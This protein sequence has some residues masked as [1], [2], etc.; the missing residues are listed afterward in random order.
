MQQL[1]E[2]EN[3]IWDRKLPETVIERIHLTVG[4]TPSDANTIVDVGSGDGRIT[5]LLRRAGYDPVACDISHGALKRIQNTRRVQAS[6]D[7]LPF[8]SFSF[9]LVIAS[10]LI[11]HIPDHI[12]PSSLKELSKISKKYI[13][14]TVPYREILE[15]NAARCPSCGCIFN[16]AYHLRSFDEER[17]RSLFTEFECVSLQK[18]VSVLHPDRTAGI[19]LFIR[20]KLAEEYLYY[21]PGIKCPLCFCRIET[22]PPRNFI[23]W[24]ATGIRFIYRLFNRK[25]TPLWFLVLYKRKAGPSL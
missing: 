17:L 5:N 21:G 9:D 14:I 24:I 25:Q 18:I 16:G 6:V 15:W 22:P 19:E 1:Y 13:L 7:H 12:F 23:G 4:M 3:D 2:N 11:E 20:H 8:L 10:E